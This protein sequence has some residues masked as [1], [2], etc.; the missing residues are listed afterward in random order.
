MQR[1]SLHSQTAFRGVGWR[2]FAPIN[3]LKKCLLEASAA[4]RWSVWEGGA[5]KRKRTSEEP[6]TQKEFEA[7]FRTGEVSSLGLGKKKRK[8]R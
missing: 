5:I 8:G 7:F 3:G 2:K 1:E 4:F 6:S